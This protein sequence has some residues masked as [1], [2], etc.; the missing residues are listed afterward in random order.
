MVDTTVSAPAPS[1]RTST[2]SYFPSQSD[3]HESGNTRP[4]PSS[5][6]DEDENLNTLSNKKAFMSQQT[7]RSNVNSPQSLKTPSTNSL[8]SLSRLSLSS[9]LSQLNALA[10]P[11][12]ASLSNNISTIPTAQVAASSLSNAAQQ[13]RKWLRKATEVLNGMDAEDDVEWAAVGG[14]EGLSEIEEAIR[15]FE[16]LISVYVSAI[17]KL[18]ERADIS[19]VSSKQLKALV[20]QMENILKEWESAR[21]QLKDVKSQVELAMEWEELWNVVMS[22]IGQEMDSL[23]SLVF[24]MEEARH[25]AIDAALDGN[26]YL[27]MQELDTIIEETP[28]AGGKAFA[29]HR[30]SLSSGY[31]P[32]SP[33]SPGLGIPQDD[34]RLLALF[35]RMQ[36]LR[37]SLDFLPMTLA[38]FHLR[39]EKVLPSSCQELESRRKDL[40]KK[41]KTLESDAQGLRQELGEDRWVLVFR[42]AGRQAQKLCESVERS[43]S[44][45]QEAI[46]V[47]TQHINPPLLAKKVEAY[48]A[49]KSHYGPAIKKVLGIIAK[50]VTDRQTVNGEILRVHLETKSRWQNIDTSIKNMDLAIDDLT[51]N[52]NQQFRDSI[53]SIVSIDRSATGSGVDTP[54]SSPASSVVMGP[55]SGSKREPSPGMNGSNHRSSTTSGNATRPNGTRRYFSMPQGLAASTSIPQKSAVNRSFTTD[56]SSRTASPSPYAKTSATPTPGARPQRPSLQTDNKPRW[57]SS[58]KVDHLDFSPKAMPYPFSTPPLNRRTSQ[59]LRSPSTPASHASLSNQP[60]PSPLGRSSPVPGIGAA[61]LAHRSRN[62]TGAQ[63]SLGMRRGSAATNDTQT[64]AKTRTPPTS[65]QSN[66][67]FESVADESPSTRQRPTTSMSSSRRISMLPV[68]KHTI[69]SPLGRESV[70]GMRTASQ[71]RVSSLGNRKFSVD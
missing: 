59:T 50:G 25:K 13:I 19:K 17:E 49:K 41:W 67:S 48:E 33:L 69:S 70:M 68:P 16:G 28:I 35:A 18:Q 54:G 40:E 15:S 31:Q 9:Q 43:I 27:D 8:Y 64:S 63:S 4:P 21:R 29:A 58:A 7:P 5:S 34:S 45:L 11:D 44:K 26:G 32:S 20:D 22:D 30:L 36:P 6:E 24:E 10:L 14:R 37:A 62:S 38:N 57:N 42:N 53:S 23:S 2:G 46:D 52:K 61:T 65:A 56:R 71:G 39:A 55:T 3:P 66:K 60:L 1:K 51:K 47:G 12:P